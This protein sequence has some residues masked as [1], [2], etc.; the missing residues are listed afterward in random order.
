MHAEIDRQVEE[1][2]DLG[3]SEKDINS[4]RASP[5]V[6]VSKKMPKGAPPAYRL[7]VDFRF[8]NQLSH[9]ITFPMPRFE[10]VVDVLGSVHTQF[11]QLIT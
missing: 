5:V 9:P 8:I 11:Y 10:D 2:V 4:P 1:L 7:A 3:V 6:M